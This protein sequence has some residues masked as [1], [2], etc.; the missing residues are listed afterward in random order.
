M[1][2]LWQAGSYQCVSVSQC[3]EGGKCPFPSVPLPLKADE[4]KVP[5][6]VTNPIEAI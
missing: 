5:F 2:G 1:V 3:D 6:D 4:F